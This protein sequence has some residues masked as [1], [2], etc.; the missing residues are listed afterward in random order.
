MKLVKN[1]CLIIFI[2]INIIF[3]VGY[4]ALPI[5]TS[6]NNLPKETG[7]ISYNNIFYINN[8]NTIIDGVKSS[9]K[10]SDLTI[11]GTVDIVF[12]TLLY[13]CIAITCLI[14]IGIIIALLGL[15]FIS[16]LIFLLA[17]ILMIVVV[18]IILLIV[19]KN[20]SVKEITDYFF[21]IGNP[22][23]SYDSGAI[24]IIIS[25][26]GMFINYLIYTFLV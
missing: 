25:T 23:M 5:I 7:T 24:L 17:L 9:T 1:I 15:K 8:Y 20:S 19:T 4:A 16:K 14:V 21:S 3:T 18:S 26:A 22:T 12:K 6:H 10:Y 11:G 2:I 13:S